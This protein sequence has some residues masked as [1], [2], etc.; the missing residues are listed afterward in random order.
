MNFNSQYGNH[1]ALY[2]SVR[3]G[4]LGGAVFSVTAS[5]ERVTTA[6]AFISSDNAATPTLRIFPVSRENRS[7]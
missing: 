5:A 4:A 6:D 3:F 2:G 7:F 1:N